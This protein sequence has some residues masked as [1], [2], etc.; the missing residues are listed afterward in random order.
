MLQRRRRH[1]E[2][3]RC[4]GAGDGFES[5]FGSCARARQFSGRRAVKPNAAL[6]WT[7]EPHDRF[8][9]GAF[10]DTIASE[11]PDN[12]AWPDMQC[13]AVQDV[14]LAV[15]SVQ[16]LDRDQRRIFGGVAHVFR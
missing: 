2:N 11:Q 6:R 10:A 8:E 14:T 9:R 15:V 1:D 4:G 16:I 7:D 5:R 3:Q 12:L 13:Y